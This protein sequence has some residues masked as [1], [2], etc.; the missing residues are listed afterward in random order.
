MNEY[1]YHERAI[2]ISKVLEKLQKL[3][4]EVYGCGNGK[5]KLQMF[6]KEIKREYDIN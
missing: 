2:P 1:C 5:I 4:E 3:Q 6:I